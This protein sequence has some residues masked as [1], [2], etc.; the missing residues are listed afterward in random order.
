MHGTIKI[1]ATHHKDGPIIATKVN[2]HDV[3]FLD[4]TSLIHAL[5]KGLQIHPSEAALH[6]F[7]IK[8]GLV[9]AKNH[10]EDTNA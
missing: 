1:T 8:D 9:S 10:K 5:L 7:A 2:L 6:L 4:K 3:D